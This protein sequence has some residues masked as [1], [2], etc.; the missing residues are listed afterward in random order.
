MSCFIGKRIIVLCVCL[1]ALAGADR[2]L[3]L[4]YEL[5]PPDFSNE[6]I[7][8]T[9]AAGVAVDYRQYYPVLTKADVARY[10]TIILLASAGQIGSGL[11]L[12]ERE[13]PALAAYVKRGGRL[14][15]GVPS[16]PLPSDP[17]AFHQLEQYN[18]LLTELGSGI[19]VRPAIADDESRRYLSAMFPQS[20]FA[21]AP[22]RRVTCK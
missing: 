20:Y 21:P 1:R 18:R 16:D 6:L 11:Q 10:R 8:R 2:A 4:D 19:Q 9:A 5:N 17:E 13:I 12:D 14:V 22:D 7:R 3:I 15:L